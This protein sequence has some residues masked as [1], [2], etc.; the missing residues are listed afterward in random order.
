V[1]VCVCVCVCEFSPG[2][3]P[4]FFTVDISSLLARVAADPTDHASRHALALK[5]FEAGDA[6]T[7]MT[8][9]LELFKRARAWND[10]AGASVSLSL[11]LYLCL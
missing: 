2:W 7:A 5:Q 6:D 8:T 11:C 3:F 9:A 10:D 1:C 4:G